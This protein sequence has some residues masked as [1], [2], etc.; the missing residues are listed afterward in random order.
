M[1][2]LS[3]TQSHSNIF[4][5]NQ[6]APKIRRK[7][8][9]RSR[10]RQNSSGDLITLIGPAEQLLNNLHRLRQQLMEP[11]ALNNVSTDTLGYHLRQINRRIF[12]VNRRVTKLLNQNLCEIT[13]NS[14]EIAE[15]AR[16]KRKD[17]ILEVFMPYVLALD[18]MLSLQQ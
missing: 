16:E 1:E 17:L 14:S 10:S 15:N 13:L 11:N 5:F 4:D 2:A 6:P 3:N 18:T 8:H 9:R 12:K 7:S